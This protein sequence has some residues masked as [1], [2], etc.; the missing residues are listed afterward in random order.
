MGKHSLPQSDKYVTL[1][2]DE[3]LQEKISAH[4][5]DVKKTKAYNILFRTL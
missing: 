5:F 2:A 1:I 3:L 4:N